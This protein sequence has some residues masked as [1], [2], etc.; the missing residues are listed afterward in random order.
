[1]RII[2]LT[3]TLNETAVSYPGTPP[4]VFEAVSA[5]SEEGFGETFI[6]IYSHTGTHVD[7]PAHMIPGGAF[8]D[9]MPVGSFCGSA[10]ILDCSKVCGE[11]GVSILKGREE[12]LKSDFL[13]LST[14]WEKYWGSP[15]Y[16]GNFPV[17]SAEAV[18]FLMSNG[19][20]GIGMDTAS[21]DRM[22]SDGFK[23]HFKVLGAG[24]VIVEN[25]C[26][27]SALR[28]RTVYVSMLP[29]KFL[30]SD[31]APVRAVAFEGELSFR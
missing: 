29:L 23:N 22:D 7:A 12:I 24:G 6:K 13:I 26:N 9:E 31:G 1:M 30:N 3:H 5:I 25:L 4:P 15:E 28:G 17:L 20:K 2:D 16:F 14:G 21:I 27:L 11:I 18:D 10:Y 19:L 8:L